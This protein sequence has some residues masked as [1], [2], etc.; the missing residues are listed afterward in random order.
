MCTNAAAGDFQ[1]IL[2]I[3]HE[4]NDMVEIYLQEAP[5]G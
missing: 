1:V 3:L 4:D 5:Q 2:P